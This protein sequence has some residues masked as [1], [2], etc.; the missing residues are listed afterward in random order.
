MSD[1][2][3]AIIDEPTV[4]KYVKVRGKQ[5]NGDN[6]LV[7]GWYVGRIK[8]IKRDGGCL[9]LESGWNMNLDI[10]DELIWCADEPAPHWV[11]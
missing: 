9:I 3:K 6:Q 8:E 5:Y 10:N 1:T 11:Q 4:G 7:S 2:Y